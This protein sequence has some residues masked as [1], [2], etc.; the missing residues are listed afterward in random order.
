MLVQGHMEGELWGLAVHP[1]SNVFVTASDDK[2][3][4]MWSIDTKVCV[5]V[6]VCVRARMCIHVCV[7]AC[8][9]FSACK[10]CCNNIAVMHNFSNV[11]LV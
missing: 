7:D 5:C 1:S 3:V 4:C 9:C 8:D 10:Q 6:C 11:L 2:T